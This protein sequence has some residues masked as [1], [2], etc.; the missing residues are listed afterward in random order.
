M[1]NR[2][3]WVDWNTPGVYAYLSNASHPT[4]HVV[5]EAY[6]FDETTGKGAF[7]ARDG[8]LPYKLTRSALMSF[9]RIW[10]INAKYRGLGSP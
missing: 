7:V 2:G 3:T 9:I 1:A 6:E 5:R 4:F 8:R 10:Q